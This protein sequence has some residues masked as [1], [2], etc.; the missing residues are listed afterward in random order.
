M[1]TKPPEPVTLV[2][3][4]DRLAEPVDPPAVSMM[5]QT[6]GWA[7]LAGLLGLAMVY[8]AFRAL[9]RYRANAYRREA[10]AALQG[11]SNDPARIA[12]ILRRAALAAYPRRQV[13]GLTG[14]SWLAFL[15]RTGRGTRF[16][17]LAAQALLKSPYQATQK[18]PELENLAE[19]WIRAHRRED[20]T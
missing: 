13:A 10:V 17:G 5:P 8:M 14:P 11:A 20:G 4:L 18:V 3:L 16:E 7:V 6:W 12:Q 15:N 9:R 19:G 2:D 1:S